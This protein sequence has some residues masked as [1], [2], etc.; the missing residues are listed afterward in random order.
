MGCIYSILNKVNGK[1]Y[2]GLTE[3]PT[4]RRT[5][6][7][8]ELRHRNH[9]NPHLQNA[10]NKYGEEN[11]EYHILEHCDDSMLGENE[12]WWISYFDSTNRDIGYNLQSGGDRGYS[13]S[14][15]TKKRLSE[16]RK[17][18]P[19]PEEVKRK[20]SEANSG[21]KNPFYGKKHTMETKLHLSKSRNN[22]GYY[23][24]TKERKDDVK[25]GFIW[26]Y[27]YR[28]AGGKQKKFTSVSL[29][30][31]KQKVLDNGLDWIEL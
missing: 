5:E 21:E 15:E 30:K 28:D 11:F 23:R 4:T 1:I 3:R 10:W 8:S 13:I 19:L 26:R 25:Q 18:I 9:C 6:H 24:V 27:S 20:I 31:V 14:E 29:D 16:E 17:G 12:D 7:F 2:I 22:T